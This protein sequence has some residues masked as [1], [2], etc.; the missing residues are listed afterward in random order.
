MMIYT[1]LD[2]NKDG[3]ISMDEFGNSSSFL[4]RKFYVISFEFFFEPPTDIDVYLIQNASLQSNSFRFR[5]LWK[6]HKSRHNISVS[7]FEYE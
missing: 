1:T 4:E 6:P 3:F 5:R 7:K 2:I